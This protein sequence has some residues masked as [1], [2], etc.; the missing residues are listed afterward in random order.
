MAAQVLTSAVCVALLLSVN[1]TGAGYAS[2]L[3]LAFLI[4]SMG[5]VSGAHFNPIVTWA[6]TLRG[7]FP[8]AWLPFYWL[9]QF[10]GSLLA[11]GFLH[12]FYWQYAY[13]GTTEVNPAYQWVTGFCYEAVL[14]FIFMSAVLAVATRGGNVGPQAALADGFVFAVVVMIGLS[15]TGTSVNPFRALGPGIVNG[16]RPDLWVYVAGPFLGSTCSVLAVWALNGPLKPEDYGTAQ[17]KGA[18]EEED[19]GDDKQS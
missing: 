10:C 5:E 18:P 11:G 9:A 15:Y 16:Y 3:A 6:F 7:L 1:Q 12:A 14:T 2:G 13:L 17:G 19:D 4:Y 8:M